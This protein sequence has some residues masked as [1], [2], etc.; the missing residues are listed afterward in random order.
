MKEKQKLKRDLYNLMSKKLHSLHPLV[1]NLW[2]HPNWF[3]I[4]LEAFYF[5]FGGLLE[6]LYIFMKKWSI[7]SNQILCKAEKQTNKDYVQSIETWINSIFWHLLLLYEGR[8]HPKCVKSAHT[9]S[10]TNEQCERIQ[11]YR[12]VNVLHPCV[13]LHPDCVLHVPCVKLHLLPMV[14]ALLAKS[15]YG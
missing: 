14:L 4:S 3:N 10:H 13:R 11:H 6:I 9:F 5:F 1:Q 7:H 15:D 12:I 8:M 2:K